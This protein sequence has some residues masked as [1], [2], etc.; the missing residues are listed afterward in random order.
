M[1]NSSILR[2]QEKS[3][4]IPVALL[5]QIIEKLL[6]HN[7]REALRSGFIDLI[8]EWYK[9][10]QVQFFIGGPRGLLHYRD[11]AMAEIVI[12]DVLEPDSRPITLV[13]DKL[14]YATVESQSSQVLNI[15]KSHLVDVY[16]PL[17]QGD[18]I[19]AVLVVKA[20][21]FESVNKLIWE[22][23]ISAFNHLNR[24][25]YAAEIDHLTGLMNRLAFDRLLSD[26]ESESDSSTVQD[27]VYLAMVDIDFFKKINDNFG[28]VF[29]D[30]VLILLA[31][32]MHESFRSM[33]WLFRYGGEE[34]AVILR[35]ISAAD[36]QQIL[37]RLRVKIENTEFAQVGYITTS[38]GYSR[39]VATEPIIN[40]VE[41]AD[42]ALYY[43][44]AHGRNQLSFYE[45]LLEQGLIEESPH[46]VGDIELF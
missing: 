9:P 36:A 17:M 6:P 5:E 25:L 42:K 12:H 43:V 15:H 23:I 31:R 10:K 32:V 35:N 4:L 16:V 18:A 39:M 46:V 38:I 3:D 13:E 30:E 45:D 2:Q 8:K 7:N 27:N 37:E 41:R 20:I 24:M 19:D 34:F 11:Q 28:H 40:L 14:L 22:Q 29:G 21:S 1:S 26:V 44:K 33:D